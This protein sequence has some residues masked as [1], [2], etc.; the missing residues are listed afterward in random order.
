MLDS[1]SRLRKRIILMYHAK[2]GPL[3]IDVTQINAWVLEEEY[4]ASS[5]MPLVLNEKTLDKTVVWLFINMAKPWNIVQSL[6]KWSTVLTEELDKLRLDPL[7]MK[8]YQQK[9]EYIG[10]RSEIISLTGL[11]FFKLKRLSK[12]T[13]IPLWLKRPRLERKAKWIYHLGKTLDDEPGYPYN[14][15]RVKGMRT[16]NGKSE[17]RSGNHL[18]STGRSYAD[19]GE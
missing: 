9:R 14:R 11:V 3:W 7:L 16:V 8:N 2:H 5:L 10:R 1:P 6:E 19:A 15:R 12:N 17:S 18:D 4:F 13:L